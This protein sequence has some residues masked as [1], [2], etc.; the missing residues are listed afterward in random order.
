LSIEIASGHYG[1]VNL[2]IAINSY[3]TNAY[4]R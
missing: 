3:I 2:H 4:I 1:N